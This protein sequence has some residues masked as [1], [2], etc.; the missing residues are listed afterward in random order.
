MGHLSPATFPTEAFTFIA[1]TDGM[2]LV[3]GGRQGLRC[4]VSSDGV[5]WQA[6]AVAHESTADLRP[7][8]PGAETPDSAGRPRLFCMDGSGRFVPTEERRRVLTASTPFDL[9]AGEGPW[10]EAEFDPTQTTIIWDEAN[11]TY[12]AFFCARRKSGRRPERRAC[13]GSATSSDLS[14]WTME[15]PVFA[16]NRFAD[17]FAPHVFTHEGRTVLCYATPEVGR[18]RALRFAIAPR[19]EGPYE[20]LEPDLIARDC[21]TSIHTV[22]AG[23]ERLVFFGRSAPVPEGLRGVSRPGRLTFRPDGR[24]LVRFYDKL[25]GLMGRQIMTTDASLSSEEMLARIFPRHGS[26]FRLIVR[27]KNLGARM[28]GVLCRTTLTGSDNIALWLDF[29]SGAL[30]MRRGVRGRL[31]ARVPCRLQPYTEYTVA[32]WAEG[33]F[34]DVFLDDEW[35]LSAFTEDRRAGYF[36]L[37]VEGGEARFDLASAQA[38]AP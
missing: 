31:L 34:L 29:A 20:T 24:P 38:I 17:M 21:R 36:G 6:E 5:H 9:A 26:D 8:C 37:A 13:I 7:I 4:R 2:A 28:V 33:S 12:R 14:R 19:P 16:P 3:R 27:L 11:S 30:V 10:Y 23:R 25:L 32:I 1:H 15:P 18:L 35:S 22:A